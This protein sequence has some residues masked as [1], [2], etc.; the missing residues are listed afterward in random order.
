[1]NRLNCIFSGKSP[2][3]RPRGNHRVIGTQ[4]RRGF[5]FEIVSHYTN[6]MQQKRMDMGWS[7]LWGFTAKTRSFMTITPPV[8]PKVV[9]F[10]YTLKNNAGEKIESS[11]GDQPISFLEGAQQIIVGLEK[12]L[13]S[14]TSGEEATIKVGHEE[15][16]G[17]INQDL[18]L[19]VDLQKLPVQSVKVGD[20]FSN[21]AN[22]NLPLIVTKVEENHVVL[23]GNHPLAGVDLTF[24]VKIVNVRDATKEEVEHGHAHGPGHTHHH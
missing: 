10:H 22:P 9:T 20:K 18:I 14:L 21:K 23:D 19:H 8:R 15:A 16:Y 2:I 11:F 1:M 24:D 3:L 17:S 13:N 4:P 7:S 5:T 6:L 12:Q